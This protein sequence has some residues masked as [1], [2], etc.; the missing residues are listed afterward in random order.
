MDT[1]GESGDIWTFK[2][3]GGRWVW[4]HRDPDGNEMASS[5]GDFETLERCQADATRFGYRAQNTP[6]VL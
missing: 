1:S 3:E 6:R 4:I 2:L 5:R